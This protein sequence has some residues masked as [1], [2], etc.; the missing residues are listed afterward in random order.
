MCNDSVVGFI[1]L[2]DS[3]SRGKCSEGGIRVYQIREPIRKWG[4]I[5]PFANSCQSYEYFHH[6]SSPSRTQI[7][8]A[9]AT[10]CINWWL[11]KIDV[12]CAS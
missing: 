10:H 7:S 1:Y 3:G 9:M 6:M 12:F 8:V 4:R 11:R 2:L 5:R